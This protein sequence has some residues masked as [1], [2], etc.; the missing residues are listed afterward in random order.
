MEKTYKDKVLQDLVDKAIGTYRDN[1]KLEALDQNST[2]H[3]V[4][5]V[6]EG[7]VNRTKTRLYHEEIK[8]QQNLED[9]FECADE[10]LS[11]KLEREKK[12]VDDDWTFHFV[13]FA[14]DISEESMKKRWG[15]LLA[16]EIES[17]GSYSLR[18][19]I[20]L[21]Q[22]TK[23]EA[24]I[25]NKFLQRGLFSDNKRNAVVLRSKGENNDLDLSN[26]LFMQELGL[27]DANDS[28]SITYNNVG[29]KTNER[30]VV[31]ER[32]GTGLVFSFQTE[33]IEFPVYKFTSIG[34]EFLLLN[35][36]IEVDTDYLK[37]VSQSIYEDKDTKVNVLCCKI[38]YP[39]PGQWTIISNEMLFEIK[40]KYIEN[41]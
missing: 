31:F 29:Y 17:P 2:K 21:S 5:Q 28:L 33:M 41:S 12:A 30:N 20:L 24:E 36:E 1:L 27:I 38:E 34:R 32:N 9:I 13:R 8:R 39:A 3:E 7:L 6:D 25:V 40:G 11:N 35:K 15:N 14:K 16:G 22:M 4:A 10:M 37:K 26:L 18:M 23:R 19:M